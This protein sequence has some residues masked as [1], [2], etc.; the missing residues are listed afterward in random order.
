MRASVILL[1]VLVLGL[2]GG[3]G[4]WLVLRPN[5]DA[6]DPEDLLDGV[7]VRPSEGGEAPD[8]APAAMRATADAPP[9]IDVSG[10]PRVGLL[11]PGAPPP[12]LPVDVVERAE[13]GIPAFRIS[14]RGRLTGGD[15]VDAVS[16]LFYV[17]AA[18][19]RDLDALE[20]L[21]IPDAELEGKESL[22]FGGM[23]QVLERSGFRV[24]HHAGV[25]IL[26]DE[27]RHEREGFRPDE[28]EPPPR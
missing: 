23:I 26:E 1:L 17:R 27:R 21:R 2:A 10:L 3:L 4:A 24:H 20:R 8:S 11:A 25:L 12:E 6:C 13:R 22:D 28:G 18:N 14:A 16:E 5:E 19:Q 9:A 15:L 7:C